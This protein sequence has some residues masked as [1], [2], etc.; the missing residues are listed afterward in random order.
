MSSASRLCR[1]DALRR[2]ELTDDIDE[3]IE[4]TKHSD[5]RVRRAALKE[6]CP[7]HVKQDIEEFWNRVLEMR[8]DPDKHVRFQVRLDCAYDRNNVDIVDT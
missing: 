6:M 1:S 8:N 7:C 3:V 2:C 5:A 4:L